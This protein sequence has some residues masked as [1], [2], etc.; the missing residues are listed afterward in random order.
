MGDSNRMRDIIR[1][2]VILTLVCI[3]AAMA[4]ARVYEF[5]KEPIAQQRRLARLRAVKGVLPEH[6]N[7]PDQDTIEIDLG[8]GDIKLVYLGLSGDKINGVAFEIKNGEGYGGEIVAMLG[9]KT[10]GEIYGVEIVRH[11]ETPGLGAKIVNQ[12]FRDQFQ[13]KSLE[14]TNFMLKK[15]G[16]DLDQITGATISP[17]AIIKGIK[18]GLEF[19]NEYKS[20]ILTTNSTKNI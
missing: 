2:V 1:L 17:R 8:N 20:Q 19:Y 5:T 16:G 18:E 10:N 6:E 9:L 11:G 12:G 3:V 7:Q 13:G 14:N 15:D 4:L